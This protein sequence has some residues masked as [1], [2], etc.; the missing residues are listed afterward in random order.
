[1]VF[2][3]ILINV[4]R[5]YRE[6]GFSSKKRYPLGQG[7][8]TLVEENMGNTIS[9]KCDESAAGCWLRRSYIVASK[10]AAFQYRAT[11]PTKFNV[12][13]VVIYSCQKHRVVV[14]RPRNVNAD[15]P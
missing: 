15:D 8:V 3:N 13:K 12:S 1:M 9:T 5:V 6:L 10:V 7:T 11:V 4:I 2:Q 14:W